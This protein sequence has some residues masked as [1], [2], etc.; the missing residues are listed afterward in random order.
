MIDVF[1]AKTVEDIGNMGRF[2]GFIWQSLLACGRSCTRSKSYRLIWAQ[3][4]LIGVRS[5][6]VI[7]VTGAFV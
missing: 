5:V 4:H 1:G 6:P 2:A 7:M 3:M